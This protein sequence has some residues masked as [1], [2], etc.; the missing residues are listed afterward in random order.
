M[1]IIKENGKVQWIDE[2]SVHH[3]TRAEARAFLLFSKAEQRRHQQ[4]IDNI[5]DI[6]EKVEAHLKNMQ[7]V[8]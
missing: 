6:V 8:K 3:L 2:K 1:G 7:E 4:D 5:E